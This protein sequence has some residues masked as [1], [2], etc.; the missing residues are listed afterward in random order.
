MPVFS[1]GENDLFIQV[2]NPD[3]SML[4]TIQLKITKFFGVSPPQF[5]GRGV[6]NYNYGL[7]PFRRTINTVG[8]YIDDGEI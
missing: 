3:G 8:K 1:F 6:F 2:P 5:H 7:V 4:K